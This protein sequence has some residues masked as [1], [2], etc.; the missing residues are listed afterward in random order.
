MDEQHRVCLVGGSDDETA[1]FTLFD[2]SDLCRL[3]CAYPDKTVEG[4]AT[5]FFLALCDVR[6]Q[7]AKDGLIPFCYGASLNVYPTGMARDMGRRLRAYQLRRGPARKKEMISSR[8]LPKVL[9]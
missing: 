5:D 2:E 1:V 6:G 4:A 8:Y 3:R 7:L 9:M